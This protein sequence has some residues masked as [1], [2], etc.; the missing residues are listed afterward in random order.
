MP[1]G[2]L[3]A[4]IL[5]AGAGVTAAAVAGTAVQRNLRRRIAADPENE[6]LRVPAAGTPSS[7]RSADGTEIHVESFGPS[8]APSAVLI[9]G[10]T[11]TLAFWSYEVRELERRGIRSVAYDL[12]GHGQSNP[13]A[14]GDYALARFGE[15]LEA[16]LSACVPDGQRAVVAGHSLGAMSIAAWA[17]HH[18]VSRQAGAAALVNT[19]MDHLIAE[20]L[21]M[22]LPKIAQ[23]INQTVAVRGFLG[24]RAPLPRFSTPI[25]HAAIRYAAFGP[26]ATPAQVA[27]FER[28]LINCDPDVRAQVGIALSSM[29]LHEAL[30]KLTLPTAVIAGDKDRLTP[31]AHARR[32]AEMLPQLHSLTVLEGV[33]HMGPLERPQEISRTLMDLVAL[34]SGAGAVA[35]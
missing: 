2:G 27:F 13:A 11:E 5:A 14:G 22:P 29:D 10:W 23:A 17:E 19:G 30:A 1:R 32:I 9:H 3:D 24:S 20:S 4:R 34:T 28:M 7:V 31:P 18:D 21:L 25:S 15:D 16:V 12:R 35:A 26:T 8:S 33:G 6:K